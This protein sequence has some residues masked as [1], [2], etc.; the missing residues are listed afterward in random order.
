MVVVGGELD[1]VPEAGRAFLKVLRL[2]RETHEPKTFR[3]EPR[4]K[5][6]TRGGTA[7]RAN[8]WVVR[9]ARRKAS[10]TLDRGQ[11]GY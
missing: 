9:K 7:R 1:L 4:P 8:G 3:A 5:G 2:A 10:G 6:W 11:A